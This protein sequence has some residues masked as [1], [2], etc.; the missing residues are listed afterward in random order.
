MIYFTHTSQVSEIVNRPRSTIQGVID[1]YRDRKTLKNKS[2][3]GCTR[4]NEYTG[5]QIICQI[6][7]N[8]TKIAIQCIISCVKVDTTY[9]IICK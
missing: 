6:K 8:T 3:S 2:R 1:R 4:K 5:Q 9:N 7:R